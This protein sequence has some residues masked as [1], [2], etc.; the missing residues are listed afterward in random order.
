MAHTEVNITTTPINLKA[1]PVN[2][3]EGSVY[4]IQVKGD[5]TVN[6]YASGSVAPTDLSIGH[7]LEPGDWLAQYEVGS[8]NIWAW[9]TVATEMSRLA[10][11]WN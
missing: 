4:N 6:W 3:Q 11:S 9:R 7:E 8:D 5:V 1:A 10:I 2:L